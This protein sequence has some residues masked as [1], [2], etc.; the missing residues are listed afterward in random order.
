MDVGRPFRTSGYMFYSNA[1]SL[2]LLAVFHV[3]SRLRSCVI[4]TAL[5]A[6]ALT[7][8]TPARRAP[9]VP[10]VPTTPEA[11]EAML[12]LAGVTPSDVVYDLGCGDG[13]IVVAAGKLGA[14]GVGIDID[15]VRVRE[16]R[17]NVEKAGVGKLVRIEEGD[18]FQANIRQASVVILFLLPELNVKLLPKLLSELKPGTRIVSNSFDMGDWAAEKE[19]MVGDPNKPGSPFS[20]QLF[21]WTVPRGGKLN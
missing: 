7:A 16:A 6:A 11:V 12:K 9:D 20:H 4:L 10:Y 19:I 2:R 21:L 3:T 1:M 8:Q 14:R 18:I 13:R 5:A 17:A 15:P